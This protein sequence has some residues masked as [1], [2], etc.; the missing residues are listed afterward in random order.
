[1]NTVSYILS[2][3]VSEKDVHSGAALTGLHDTTEQRG[4]DTELTGTSLLAEE[5][6]EVHV[7]P[8]MALQ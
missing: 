1:M 3:A 8:K 4:W 7:Q 2:T 6:R 5:Q